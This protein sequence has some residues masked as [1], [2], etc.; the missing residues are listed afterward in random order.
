MTIIVT[1]STLPTPGIGKAQ[2]ADTSTSSEPGS[3]G[4]CACAKAPRVVG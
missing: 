2:G 4:P 1:P 3:A